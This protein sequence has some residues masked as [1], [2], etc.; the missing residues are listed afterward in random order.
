ME[1]NIAKLQELVTTHGLTLLAAIAIFFIGKWIVGLIVKGCDKIFSK[2]KLDPTLAN[3]LK[4][5]LGA[6]GMTFVI[7][8]VLAKLGI[9][10]ASFIAVLGAAGLAVGMALQG[11]LSNFAAG[12]LVILFKPY[13][14][15]DFINAGGV[16]GTVKEVQIFNTI[17]ATPDNVCVILPNAQALG[18][19]ITNYST[20]PTRRVDLVIGVS[21][22]D[23][24]KKTK[25]VLESTVNADPRVLKDPAPTIAVSALADSSVN[26]VVRPWVKATDYWATYFALTENI[27]INLDKNGITIPFPQRDIHVQTLPASFQPGKPVEAGAR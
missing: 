9:Q 22:S 10:T 5:L 13:K 2:S 14:T 19:H 1:E 23:D 26:F 24:L 3:F 8:A 25:E 17:L 4:N 21:Y 16:M 20:N 12:V 11:S 27:K 7:L 15:G 6:A 18:S